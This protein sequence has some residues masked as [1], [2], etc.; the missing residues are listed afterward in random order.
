[1]PN[2]I[3]KRTVTV[4]RS[5][6]VSDPANGARMVSQPIATNLLADIQINASRTIAGSNAPQG[7][8][9]VSPD[10]MPTW[11]LFCKQKVRIIKNDAVVDDLLR[12]FVVL[13]VYET[14]FGIQ[15]D[16]RSVSV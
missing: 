9:L 3:Y 4:S 8:N 6:K 11:T 2:L 10:T 16:M 5:A 15:A 14:P 7:V 12:S 1:M 13:A